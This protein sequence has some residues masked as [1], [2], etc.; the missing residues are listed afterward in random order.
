MLVCSEGIKRI[1]LAKKIAISV[2]N[3]AD[4]T[5]P[6]NGLSSF[7]PTLKWQLIESIVNFS[8]QS[9]YMFQNSFFYDYTL[10][11]GD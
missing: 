10:T 11:N 7:E 2:F 5:S 3:F 9:A 6:K 8:I 4:L 1:L